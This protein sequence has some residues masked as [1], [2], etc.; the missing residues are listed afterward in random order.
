MLNRVIRTLVVLL[1]L[2]ALA[3]TFDIRRQKDS[4]AELRRSLEVP[5]DLARPS[6]SDTLPPAAAPATPAVAPT[7]KPAA[8][9]A[10]T[11][12]PAAV[13]DERVRLERDGGLRWLVVRDEPLRVSQQVRGYFVRNA[14]KL[15][16]DDVVAMKF[17]TDWIDR[18]VK[19]GDGFISNLFSKLHSTGLRDKYRVR[20]EP[21]RVPGTAEIYVSHQGLELIVTEAVG[22]NV[23]KTEW[24]PRAADPQAEVELLAQLMTDFGGDG[25]NALASMS[26][27]TAQVTHVK[28]DIRL[29]GEDFDGAWRRVGQ[30]LDRGGVI[31]EDRDR[32]AGAYYVQFKSSGA[33]KDSGLFGWLKS[34]KTLAEAGKEDVVDRYQVVIKADSGGALVSVRDVRGDLATSAAGE[35]LLNLINQQVH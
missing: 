14:V 8:P 19:M 4:S 9:A 23:M 25:K 12:A 5:P 18:P 3:C 11:A 27:A 16:G 33:K 35:E 34:G 6:G 22:V 1:A 10:P 31:I 17:E 2:N 20:V 29:S 15:V 30:A 24:F 13:S 32:A 7:A 26:A 28:G 21:G